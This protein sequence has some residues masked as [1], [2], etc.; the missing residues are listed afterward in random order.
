[1]F[2]GGMVLRGFRRLEGGLRWSRSTGVGVGLVRRCEFKRWAW[3]CCM[4]WE[5]FVVSSG[6]GEFAARARAS[7]GAGRQ[8]GTAWLIYPIR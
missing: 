1:M 8:G 4:G 6:V 7:V 2:S 5:D 3:F